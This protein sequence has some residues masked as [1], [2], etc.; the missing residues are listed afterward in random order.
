[1]KK[2]FKGFIMLAGYFFIYLGLSNLI[3]KSG[4]AV[5]FILLFDQLE[6]GIILYQ[7]IFAFLTAVFLFLLSTK[8]LK[9][10]FRK[11]K[12]NLEI[13]LVKSVMYVGSMFALLIA[14]TLVKSYFIPIEISENQDAI[15]NMFGHSP[16]LMMI[17]ACIFAPFIE[18]L[19]FRLGIRNLI[20][21]NVLYIIVSA[22][23]FG[24]IHVMGGDYLNIFSY[25]ALG[26]VLAYGYLK[27]DNIFMMIFVHAVYNFVTFLFIL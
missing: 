13:N 15:N 9:D 8:E 2:M 1:M 27:T 11:F 12:E 24:F 18:E 4:I 22:L 21:N 23:S 10:G 6:V 25:A 17:F 20:K 3:V 26:L 14:V 16:V 19:A 7:L 5:R